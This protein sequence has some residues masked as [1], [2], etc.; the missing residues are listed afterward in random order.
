MI[1]TP[2]NIHDAL[3]LEDTYQAI[4]NSWYNL[5]EDYRIQEI[6]SQTDF[7]QTVETCR[8]ILYDIQQWRNHT[9]T[10]L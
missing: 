5:P 10:E 1:Q 8:S 3:D 7:Y 4:L 2:D 6:F 9:E